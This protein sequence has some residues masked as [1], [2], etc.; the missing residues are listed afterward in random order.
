MKAKVKAEVIAKVNAKVKAEV[1]AKANAEVK[2]KVIRE[3]LVGS[4][5]AVSFIGKFT[6]LPAL[7]SVDKKAV[8]LAQ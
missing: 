2:A 5:K 7:T 8:E 6:K 3:G 4:N 1:K